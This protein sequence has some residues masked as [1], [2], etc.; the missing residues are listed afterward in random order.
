VDAR[1]VRI[2]AVAAWSL[3]KKTAKITTTKGK[4]VQTFSPATDAKEL[5]LKHVM[6]PSGNLRAP[7]YRLGNEFVIGFNP[8]LYEE[9]LS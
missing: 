7:S 5:I 4:K 9:W 8:D 3:L 2:D 1:K 6:G